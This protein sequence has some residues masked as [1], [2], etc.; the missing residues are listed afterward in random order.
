MLTEKANQRLYISLID[1]VGGTL[2]ETVWPSQKHD[3]VGYLFA[4]L[5]VAVEPDQREWSKRSA[6]F[7]EIPEILAVHHNFLEK[8]FLQWLK[9]ATEYSSTTGNLGQFLRHFPDLIAAVKKIWQGSTKNYEVL[10]QIFVQLKKEVA[11]ATLRMSK[12]N[13]C[14]QASM[15]PGARR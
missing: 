6:A 2:K 13:K 7:F 11:E 15:V 3:G 12:V 1:K 10:Q 14:T 4:V 8:A 9:S 5:K